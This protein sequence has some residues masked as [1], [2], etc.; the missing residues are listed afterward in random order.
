MN[1]LITGVTSGIGRALTREYI[2]GGHRVV[3]VARREEILKKMKE[4]YK[5][6]FEYICWDISETSELDTLIGRVE[7]TVEKVDILIN[8]AGIGSYGSLCEGKAEDE[9]K[10]IDINISSLT[11][12]T[13]RYLERMVVRN[14]GGIINVSST[15]AFQRGG[16]LMASYYGT[17]SYVLALDEGIRGELERRP[18]N[19][20]RVMTL[21]PGPTSTDFVGMG[22]SNKKK[23]YISTPQMV[24]RE[25]C[26][27]YENGKEIVIPGIINKLSVFFSSCLPRRIQRKVVYN[28]QKKKRP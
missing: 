7:G 9:Q 6:S 18:G 8:N 20:V 23:F 10:M 5:D 25:C 15:A 22:S 2:Y 11:Y 3:G 27:G 28:I 4:E 17:K 1:I 24:A 21:C 26:K 16:P 13:K 19:K 12:L 14:S